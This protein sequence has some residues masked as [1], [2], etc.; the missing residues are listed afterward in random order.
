M[1]LS[2]L[3][4]AKRPPT[5]SV[6]MHRRRALWKSAGS[7]KKACGLQTALALKLEQRPER[8]G[9][10]LTRRANERHL[11]SPL[12]RELRLG[13]AEFGAQRGDAVGVVC[14]LAAHPDPLENAFDRIG[15]R[16]ARCDLGVQIRCSSL[17]CAPLRI[18]PT[19]RLSTRRIS[20]LRST[21][22]SARKALRKSSPSAPQKTSPSMT[23][24]GTPNT[25]RFAAAA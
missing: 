2:H 17:Q 18:A 20:G 21:A 6:S 22:S 24:L 7:F 13:N 16:A 4:A 8:A 25:P 11:T 9:L 1:T 5:R 10:I 12:R 3:T 14:M 23:K 19:G 15:A